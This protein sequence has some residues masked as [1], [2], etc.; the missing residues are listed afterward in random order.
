LQNHQKVIVICQF[1]A[2]KIYRNAE[3]GGGKILNCPSMYFAMAIIQCQLRL[4]F[5]TSA[6][7]ANPGYSA[8]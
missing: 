5:G 8:Q 6:E 7:A 3:E 1:I 4:N 2:Q